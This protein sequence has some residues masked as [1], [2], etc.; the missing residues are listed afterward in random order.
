MA[1]RPTPPAGLVL[2]VSTATLLVFVVI[3]LSAYIRLGDAGLGCAEWPTCFGQIGAHDNRSLA[4]G[5][6]LLP[7]SAARSFHRVA[8]TV[9]G[10]IVIGIVVLAARRRREAPGI[11][12]PLLVFA[13]TVF[14]SVLGVVTPSPLV[15]L[16]TLGN[17][18]GGMTLLALLWVIG[19]RLQPKPS[20]EPAAAQSLRPWAR[21][22]LVAVV[23]QIALGAWTS[24]S[25]AGP[26]CPSLAGCE[27]ASLSV[28]SLAQSYAPTRRVATDDRGKVVSDAN[29]KTVH[30]VHRLG[31]ALAFAAIM[32]LGLRARRAPALRSAANVL[33]ALLAIQIGIGILAVAFA[34]PLSLAALHNA[35]AALLLLAVVN[36]NLHLTTKPNA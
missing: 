16:V 12:L 31:A 20:L 19:Q 5:G 27:G 35:N 28:D 4:E 22:A 10:F 24:G 25:F 23:L 1:E 32:L 21:G 2:M 3:V 14:L 26:A 9:F 36:L 17:V 30:A 34:L 11:V 6:P 15:P 13:L 29:Q 8:A 7:P 18:L 33:L